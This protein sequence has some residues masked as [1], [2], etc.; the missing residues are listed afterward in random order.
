MLSVFWIGAH[1][2]AGALDDADIMPALLAVNILIVPGGDEWS[3]SVA[4]GRRGA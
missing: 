2:Y 3:S 4:A 1:R